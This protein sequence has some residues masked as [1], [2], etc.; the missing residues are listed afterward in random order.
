MFCT[1]ALRDYLSSMYVSV[2]GG[3]TGFLSALYADTGRLG[4]LQ[5]YERTIS[6]HWLGAIQIVRW[7]K[8][9]NF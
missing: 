9:G 2:Q 6:L 3:K 4:K 5:F 1:L 7:L 8:F